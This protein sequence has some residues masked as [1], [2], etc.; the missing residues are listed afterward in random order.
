MIVLFKSLKILQHVSVNLWP[1]SR[2]YLPEDG[3]RLTE[4]EIY[5]IKKHIKMIVLL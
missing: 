5:L 3:Q 1:S 4:T 2:R